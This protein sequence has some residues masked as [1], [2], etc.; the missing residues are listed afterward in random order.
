MNIPRI[1]IKRASEY[2]ATFGPSLTIESQHIKDL[3]RLSIKELLVDLGHEQQA[4]FYQCLLDELQQFQ[5]K[6][7]I[8]DVVH[9]ST[10]DNLDIEIIKTQ[11]LLEEHNHHSIGSRSPLK[12]Q[13]VVE[14][15]AKKTL[16]E[17]QDIAR[18]YIQFLG[19]VN[20]K[21]ESIMSPKEYE[22]LL[23][24]TDYLIQFEEVPK[25]VSRIKPTMI[26]KDHIKYTYYLIHKSLYGTNRVKDVFIY[27]L[28]AVFQEFEKK[29]A[30]TSIKANFSHKPGSY[31]KDVKKSKNEV[32]EMT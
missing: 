22:N 24:Y 26:S 12:L 8:M 30:F 29:P 32:N 4:M 15:K 18:D 20:L 17:K 31:D 27:F 2:A 23:E 5:E 11:N 16:K 1:I 21:N 3:Q 7:M 6:L 28:I 25:G 9:E 14:V 13:G 19:G 10:L